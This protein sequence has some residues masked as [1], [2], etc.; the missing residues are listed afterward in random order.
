MKI[1]IIA[2]NSYYV[3][4]IFLSAVWI[5]KND[6]VYQIQVD[7]SYDASKPFLISWPWGRFYQS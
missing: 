5:I 7:S 6:I 1:V 4:D 2:E 3:F